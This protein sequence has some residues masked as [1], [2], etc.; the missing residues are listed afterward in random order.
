MKSLLLVTLL[1]LAAFAQAPVIEISG[2]NYRPMPIAVATAL[3]Q[4]EGAKARLAEFDEALT[5]DLA[6][7]GLFTLLDRKSFLGE[8]KEGITAASINFPNWTNV[9]A[10]A[11]V[12][13]A[14]KLA[15][16]VHRS[17]DLA[18]HLAR[19]LDNQNDARRVL[20]HDGGHGELDVLDRLGP[21][22]IDH[23]VRHARLAHVSVGR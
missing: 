7:C 1:P 13:S 2:A 22:T 20:H 14:A 23:Q 8:A 21:V 6:A 10:D 11:L 3:T 16:H 19:F 15:P 9:G 17:H 5:Y 4:D 18:I 12:R